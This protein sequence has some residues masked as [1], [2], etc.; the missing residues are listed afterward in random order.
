M[1]ELMISKRY[2]LPPNIIGVTAHEELFENVKTVF[3]DQLLWLIKYE[4]G[5]DT[6]SLALKNRVEYILNTKRVNVSAKDSTQYSVD[7][8][9][10]CALEKIELEGIRMISQDW[11]H[12]HVPQDENS[13]YY[14][15][16]IKGENRDFRIVSAAAPQMG[17]TAAT[18]LSM[19]LIQLFRPRYLVMT[20]IAAGIRGKVNLGDILVS[21]QT[22]DYGS[23]KYITENKERVFKPDPYPIRLK[24]KVR[25]KIELLAN[26][27]HALEE[28][29]R[30]WPGEKPDTPLAVHIGPVASGAAVLS[31]SSI[32]SDI[33]DQNRKLIGI[34][35]ENYGV[36][37]A[38][39]NSPNPQPT[40]ISLKSVVDFADEEKHDKV[41]K[42]AGY[43]SA[44][45]L[46]LLT[47][48]LDFS[49]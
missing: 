38:G 47:K 10:I 49:D 6:W 34:D 7:I 39:E 11:S 32:V 29:R 28:I 42:Y 12:L 45:V 9:V 26:D 22:W 30:L 36:Y 21:D 17:M 25:A 48:Y 46:K 27:S 33:L 15:S 40:V 44:A 14:S 5:S 8:A 31:S 4:V 2:P 13:N 24:P 23:G 19:K 1:R 20:G 18:A 41:Q 35:M 43:T 37:F 3:D 16:I